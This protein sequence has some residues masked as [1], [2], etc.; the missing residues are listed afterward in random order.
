M[1][2]ICIKSGRS[3][4][5][6]VYGEAILMFVNFCTQLAQFDSQVANA[7]GFFVAYMA[8]SPNRCGPL[9]KQGYHGKGLDGIANS[10]HVDFNSPQLA[11]HD[12]N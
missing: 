2:L 4:R 5:A 10:V 3:K 8:N 7:V 1:I 9:G 11:T 12:R 6:G